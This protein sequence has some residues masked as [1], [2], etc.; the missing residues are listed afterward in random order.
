MAAYRSTPHPSTG[1]SHNML[2]REVNTPFHILYPLLAEHDQFTTDQYVQNMRGKME[3]LYHLAR[4][5][6]QSQSERQKRDYDSRTC[7]NIMP[8]SSLVYKLKPTHR[9][10][11][12]PWAGPYIITQKFGPVVYKIRNKNKTEIIHH[13]K[14]K[15]FLSAEAPSWVEK[16][17]NEIKHT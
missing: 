12:F 6:L 9:K 3:Q 2:G 14:L 15:P 4:E 1:Y 10:F 7:E 13:D 11:E 8:I 5:N 16:I 17:Q